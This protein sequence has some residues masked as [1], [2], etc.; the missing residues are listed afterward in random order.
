MYSLKITWVEKILMELETF[1]MEEEESLKVW[2]RK[3]MEGNGRS[4]NV[5]YGQVMSGN[6]NKG[7]PWSTRVSKGQQVSQFQYIYGQFLK[8][9]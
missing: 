9:I 5:S 2:S 1:L 4:W 3:E 8:V 6:V 7:Q